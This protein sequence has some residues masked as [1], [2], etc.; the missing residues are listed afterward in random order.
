MDHKQETDRIV[1]CAVC[2]GLL[3]PAELS[4][5]MRQDVY[6]AAYE[7]ASCLEDGEEILAPLFWECGRG[8]SCLL[9]T[10]RRVI[11]A[12]LRAEEEFT[13][14]GRYI[15]DCSPLRNL[16]AMSI[17]RSENLLTISIEAEDGSS[18]GGGYVAEVEGL[19]DEFVENFCRLYDRVLSSIQLPAFP[20]LGEPVAPSPYHIYRKWRPVIRLGIVEA[21]QEQ[22]RVCGSNCGIVL[23]GS[24]EG[25]AYDGTFESLVKAFPHFETVAQ[26]LR[27][28]PLGSTLITDIKEG[29]FPRMVFCCAGSQDESGAFAVSFP[30]LE[31]CMEALRN[32][33]LRRDLDFFVPWGLGCGD[34]QAKWVK[35]RR[36][37]ERGVEP[38][39]EGTVSLFFCQDMN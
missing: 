9:L 5:E 37:I 7:L 26:E 32:H 16:A 21:V 28:T 38:C 24:Q 36:I 17:D 27:G 29:E 10:N 39:R 33:P 11:E 35:V 2:N 25:P 19:S 1:D 18:M 12:L 8:L 13:S 6:E 15:L 14:I 4:A 22:K 23:L 30:A 31:L 34:S 3:N 20:P